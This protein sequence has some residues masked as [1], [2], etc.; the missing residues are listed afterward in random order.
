MFFFVFVGLGFGMVFVFFGMVF[1]FYLEL[2]I[3]EKHFLFSSVSVC[4]VLCDSL[5]SAR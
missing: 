3:S 4:L 1:V 5:C 2:F